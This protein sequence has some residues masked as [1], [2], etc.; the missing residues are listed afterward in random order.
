MARSLTMVALA[1]QRSSQKSQ[2]RLESCAC[3]D[4]G[5]AVGEI[6]QLENR[7]WSLQSFDALPAVVSQVHPT[8][9]RADK[10]EFRGQQDPDSTSTPDSWH[11]P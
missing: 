8:P 2:V 11:G 4:V 3:D 9:S 6:S 7:R 10:A 5:A 1:V